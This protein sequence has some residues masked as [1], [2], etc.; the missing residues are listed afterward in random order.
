MI[1][2]CYIIIILFQA[3]DNTAEMFNSLMKEVQERADAFQ[4]QLN[5]AD[6]L[7]LQQQTKTTHDKLDRF[8]EFL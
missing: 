2:K 3:L 5:E 1:K 7:T 6:T 8:G 4:P